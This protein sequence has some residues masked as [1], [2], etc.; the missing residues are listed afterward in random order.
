MKEK[1]KKAAISFLYRSVV[2]FCIFGVLFALSRFSP[3]LWEKFSIVF[4]KTVDVDALG[5]SLGKFIKEIVPFR[6]LF[7]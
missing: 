1:I 2:C 4:T 6:E 7:S 3:N 5:N